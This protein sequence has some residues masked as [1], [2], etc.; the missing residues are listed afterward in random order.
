MENKAVSNTGPI[1]HLSEID[2]I[3]ALNIFSS[4]IIPNEVAAELRRN[5]ISIPNKITIGLLTINSK[6]RAEILSNQYDLDLGESEAIA[7]ALQEK[8]DYFLTDDLSAKR[9][10]IAYNIQTHGSLGI[11]LR[12]FREKLINKDIAIEKIRE[13]QNSSSLFITQIIINEAIKAIEELNKK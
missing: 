13:L 5:K 7:L 6:K 9:V 2:F 12:V 8:T 3:N 4:I 1:I 10:A 11:I